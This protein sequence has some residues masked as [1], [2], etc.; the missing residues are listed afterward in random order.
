MTPLSYVAGLITLLIAI[1]FR[2]S[3]NYLSVSLANTKAFCYEGVRTQNDLAPAAECFTVFN[4]TFASVFNISNAGASEGQMDFPRLS[5]YAIPGLWDG[6]GHLLHYGE[7]L[8]SVD[9]FG[10]RSVDDVCQRVR[11]FLKK[12]S[13][14]AGTAVDWIL[15]MGWDEQNLD[16][17]PTSVGTIC[18][19]IDSHTSLRSRLTP[20][21]KCLR[22]IPG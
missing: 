21:S 9:L 11:R 8:H 16:E 22:E 13:P 7:I 6:H 5:G 12:A 4:G 19:H 18:L 20:K 1:I 15:G 14:T 17:S 2:L 3:S 10:T